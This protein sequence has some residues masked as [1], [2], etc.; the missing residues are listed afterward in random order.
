M[1]GDR[2]KQSPYSIFSIVCVAYV[3]LG[4]NPLYFVRSMVRSFIRQCR[5]IVRP[6]LVGVVYRRL[7]MFM[8]F[9]K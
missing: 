2:P 7:F 8:I 3:V 1:A 4:G 9:V 5:L 6:T